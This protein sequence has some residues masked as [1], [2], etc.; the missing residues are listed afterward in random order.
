LPSEVGTDAYQEPRIV[1]AGKRL[2]V[3]CAAP[4]SASPRP[5][6][7]RRRG[8]LS[9]FLVFFIFQHGDRWC[10][11]FRTACSACVGARAKHLLEVAGGTVRGV[12]YGILARPF[13]KASS[14]AWLCARRCAGRGPPRAAHLLFVA[15]A[16]GPPLLWIPAVLWL[17]HRDATGW[18]IFLAIWG[19]GVSS[20]DNFVKPW[21]ISHG[22]RMPFVLVFFGVLGGAMAFGFIGVFLGPTL[23]AVGYRLSKSGWRPAPGGPHAATRRLGCPAA[24]APSELAP[25]PAGAPAPPGERP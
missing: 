22:S 4:S 6:P 20:I 12:V 21:L 3:A 8:V 24:P 11:E 23:L 18:A 9:V 17:F 10:R 7:G 1:T 5:R 16:D 13:S 19:L 25:S 14:R 15:G 2:L